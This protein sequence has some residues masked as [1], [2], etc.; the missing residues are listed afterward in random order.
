MVSGASAVAS[1]ALAAAAVGQAAAS[2][3]AGGATA[4]GFGAM[5]NQALQYVSTAQ[6]QSA[7][8]EAGFAAGVPGDTLAKA[9]VASDRAEVDWNATVAAR[10]ELVAAYQTIMNMQ[11]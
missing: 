5:L 1:P 9:L 2:T 7:S 6:N 10:N 3:A 8:A 4:P 11:F